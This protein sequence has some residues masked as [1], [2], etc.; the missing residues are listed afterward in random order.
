MVQKTAMG[1][2]FLFI[3]FLSKKHYSHEQVLRTGQSN[4]YNIL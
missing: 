1:K 4:V 3:A 2:N